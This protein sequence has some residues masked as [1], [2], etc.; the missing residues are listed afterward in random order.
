MNVKNLNLVESFI[1]VIM[2]STYTY[3]V[4]KRF[5]FNVTRS[6]SRSNNSTSSSENMCHYRRLNLRFRNE[7]RHVDK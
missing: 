7:Q 4:G 2:P 1:L 3:C 5:L 6:G